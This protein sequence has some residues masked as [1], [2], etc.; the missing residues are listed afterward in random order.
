VYR[1]R[2]LADP[3]SRPIYRMRFVTP[4]TQW[5]IFAALLNLVAGLGINCRGSYSCVGARRVAHRL[6][7]SIGAIDRNRWYRNREQI[8]C[9]SLEGD[10]S[11]RWFCAFLQNT[12]GA[13]GSKIL[14]LAHYIEDHGCRG[15][16][17]V[18]YYF[19]EGD[20]NVSRGELTYNSVI[21]PCSLDD[22]LCLATRNPSVAV[23][24][25]SIGM[26]AASCLL[27]LS[28]N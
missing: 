19:P 2:H 23:R 15:C 16:G 11:V 1:W 27:R 17:S 14:E 13:P 21:T 7:H 18:P 28:L 22:G 24:P 6:T 5:L 9:V 3:S 26:C 25:S 8:A 20:N 10:E 12:G 4:S